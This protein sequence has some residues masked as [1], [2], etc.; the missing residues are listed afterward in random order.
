MAALH[1]PPAPPTR[2]DVNPEGPHDDPRHG[3]FLLVLQ[4]DPPVT[5]RPTA[6]RTGDGQRRLVALIDATRS[7]PTGF[8]AIP[9]TSFP[10]RAPRILLQRL[11]EG[12]GLATRRTAR[13]V[14]LALDP[15]EFTAQS[16]ALPLQLGVLPL[17]P[18][19]LSAFR[20]TFSFRT[21]GTLAQV[22]DL[23]RPSVGCRRL[24]HAPFMAD[25]R[26]KYKYGILDLE[27]RDRAGQNPLIRNSRYNRKLWI[28]CVTKGG[29]SFV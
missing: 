10:A 23:M 5:E 28:D 19:T 20:V 25:S 24:R 7:S 2:A 3:Q 6:V 1:A 8:R 26:K 11:G 9:R 29:V 27:K 15:L 17:Q 18:I 16:V 22:V 4:H 14:Q 12:R 21:L 13:V